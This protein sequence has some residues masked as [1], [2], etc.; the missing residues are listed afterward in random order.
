MQAIADQITGIW[1]DPQCGNGLCELPKEKPAYG[2][3]DNRYGCEEDCGVEPNMSLLTLLLDYRSPSVGR[4]P[5]TPRTTREGRAEAAV[6]APLRKR[7]L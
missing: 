5:S 7:T 2:H 6:T 4:W 1:V 3:P